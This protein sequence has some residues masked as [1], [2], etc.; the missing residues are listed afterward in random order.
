MT[1]GCKIFCRVIKT[2]CVHN[3]VKAFQQFDALKSLKITK[4][5]YLCQLMSPCKLVDRSNNIF[6][7]ILNNIHI[8]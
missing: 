6:C 4:C 5:L 3:L 8:T 1:E 2:E 7:F